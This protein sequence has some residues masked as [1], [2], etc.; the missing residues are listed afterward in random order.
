M[1]NILAYNLKD[2][3]NAYFMKENGSYEPKSAVDLPPFNIHKEF[4]KLKRDTV[5][6]A[7]LF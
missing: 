4:Y 3:V 2:N 7:A 6:Q 1:I 5:E